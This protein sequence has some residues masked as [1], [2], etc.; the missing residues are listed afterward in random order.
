MNRT[1][2]VIGVG[3]TPDIMIPAGTQYSTGVVFDGSKESKLSA[4]IA[5]MNQRL[6]GSTSPVEEVQVFAITKSTVHVQNARL[7]PNMPTTA[8]DTLLCRCQRLKNKKLSINSRQEKAIPE[9]LRYK[10]H[11]FQPGFSALQII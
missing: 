7:Q 1:D 10:L 9:V 2:R 6:F 5:L 3:G 8:S 4:E 11:Y